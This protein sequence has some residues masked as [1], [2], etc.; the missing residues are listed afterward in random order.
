MLR[1]S[2]A[3][4]YAILLMTHFAA[5]GNKE[6]LSA[7]RL[8]DSTGLPLPTVGKVLKQLVKAG[9]LDST[10]GAA[11]GY[12]LPCDPERIRIADIIR[13]LE[14]PIAITDCAGPSHGECRLD[15]PCLLKPNWQQINQ[16]VNQALD[17]ITLRSMAPIDPCDC[18]QEALTRMSSKLETENE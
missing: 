14:G 18:T 16:A 8:S 10:R 9:L 15:S 3:T 1:I 13:A 4:D 7:R 12:C 11:G 17:G 5:Q 6:S 2:K